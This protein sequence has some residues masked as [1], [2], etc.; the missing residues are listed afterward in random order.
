MKKAL[1]NTSRGTQIATL[2]RAWAQLLSQLTALETRVGALE[3]AQ[4]AQ[5]ETLTRLSGPVAELVGRYARANS[6]DHNRE[7]PT[8]SD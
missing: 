3:A 6:G 1:R 2:E 4:K 7:S 5:Q 8:G